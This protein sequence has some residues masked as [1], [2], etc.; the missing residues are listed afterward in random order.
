M[1]DRSLRGRTSGETK[2]PDAFQDMFGW[3]EMV[4][5]VAEVYHALPP[6][7]RAVASIS[8]N[9]YGQ[10]AAIDFFGPKYG[11]PKAIS[12]H[13]SYWYWG[14]RDY[15]G[16]VFITVG[17][18]PEALQRAFESV[19][20]ATVIEH[21]YV[22]WY[23]TNQPVYVWRKMVMPLGDVWPRMKLFY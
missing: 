16:E 22:I 17:V 23:E 20:L 14:P 13:N 18:R 9:N 8:G 10:A 6:E 15:T 7:E 12:T 1:I 11:L 4:A 5:S 3:E 19:E 2:M 21:P